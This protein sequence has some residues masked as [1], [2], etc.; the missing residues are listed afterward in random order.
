MALLKKL[1]QLTFAGVLLFFTACILLVGGLFV[2][3]L[4]SSDSAD[5][6]FHSPNSDWVLEI[7]ESC[8][9][10]PC[11]KYPRLTVATGWFSSR[12]LQCDLAQ[13]DTTRV[14]FD[15]VVST[16]WRD[17]GTKF[18]WTAGDPPVSGTIDL[19]EDCYITA[20]YNDRPNL[21]SL[22]FH[23]NCLAGACRRWAY[24]IATRGAYDYTTPCS[25]TASGEDR[26][27]TDPEN[28]TGQI[29]VRFVPEQARAEWSS[30]GTGQT[31]AIDFAQDCDA[32]KTVRSE[33]PPG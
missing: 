5:V 13:T 9:Q 15:N 8:L 1:L 26:V 30:H 32:A 16:E 4:I 23:E 17:D 10:G 12:E 18:G 20:I 21:L 2:W 19:L 7:E 27:F 11:Y 22:R 25:A 31:G 24:W 33:V 29:S 14:L 3:K 28:P 6:A